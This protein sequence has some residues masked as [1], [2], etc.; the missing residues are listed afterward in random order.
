MKAKFKIGDR[1]AMKGVCTDD[2]YVIFGTV[3]L[4]PSETGHTYSVEY[5]GGWIMDDD[6]PNS[7]N[8]TCHCGIAEDSLLPDVGFTDRKAYRIGHM[9]VV[10]TVVGSAQ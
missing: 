5:D 4:T 9:L 3:I 2:R 1:V 7:L 8:P 10:A 6:E